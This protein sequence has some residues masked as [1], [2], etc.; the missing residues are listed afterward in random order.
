MS[1]SWLNLTNQTAVITGA[2]SGEFAK[3]NLLLAD[4]QRNN[5]NA[6]A[7]ACREATSYNSFIQSSLCNVADKSHVKALI[8]EADLI[9]METPESACNK[10]SILVNCAGITRDGKISNISDRDWDDV[11]GV[12]LRGTF[13]TCQAFCEKERVVSL[14][15]SGNRVGGS[16]VNIGSIV[17]KYGNVGQVNYSASK[18]GVVGLT[19]SLAKE[20]ALLSCKIAES[21]GTNMVMPAIRVNCIQPG[22]IETPMAHAVPDI[23]LTEISARISLRRLGGTDDVAN[24]CSFLASSQRSGYITG[25]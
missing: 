23:I 2:A 14:L 12:N 7:S 20:M 4:V 24:L 15:T 22:F 21:N 3:C 19:R 18:G 10:A 5:L 25:E 13:N 6:V 16:I 17:S 9:A 11:I 1:S 8:T